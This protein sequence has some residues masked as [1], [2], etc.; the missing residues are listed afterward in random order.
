MASD[1]PFIS[2]APPEI[3][4]KLNVPAPFVISACPSVPSETLSA[5]IPTELSA[6]TLDVI[7][8]YHYPGT[9]SSF[10]AAVTTPNV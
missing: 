4:E 5:A 8:V 1:R 6:K 3:V 9:S 2:L 10:V 7:S